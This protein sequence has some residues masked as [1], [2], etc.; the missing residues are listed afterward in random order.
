MKN[1]LRNVAVIHPTFAY[2][3]GAESLILWTLENWNKKGIKSTVYT[4]S[5]REDAPDFITQKY[6]DISLNPLTFNKT[7]KYILNE[8]FHFDAVIIHNFPASIFFGLAYRKSIKYNIK[9]P[10]SFWYCHEPSVRLYGY[11]E[12]SYKKNKGTIDIIARATMKLDRYGVSKIDYIFANSIRTQKHIE[13]VYSRDSQVIYPAIESSNIIKE[14]SPKHFLYVGRI[15]K[16]KNIEN[17]I[18]A[19]CMF[20]EKIKDNDVK[21]I[22]AGKGRYCKELIKLVCK[23][24][25]QNSV[26]FKGYI[27]ENEKRTLLLECYAFVMPAENEP[28]GL[29]AIEAFYSSAVSII[30]KYS[31]VSEVLKDAAIIIDMSNIESLCNAMLDIYSSKDLRYELINKSKNIIESGKFNIDVYASNLLESIETKL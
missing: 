26:V 16:A 31:G 14:R 19:F 7:S 9:L 11:D 1:N 4:K 28:F 6:A 3:G 22:I 29:T 27:T 30:S 25:M 13:R 23:L 5:I 18:K 15:E 2:N 17:A 8:L 24:N 12:K 21:F 10:K 20:K